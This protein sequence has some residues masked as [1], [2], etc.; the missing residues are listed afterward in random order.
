M[1][2]QEMLTFL[3]NIITGMYN[4]AD[5][6][7]PIFLRATKLLDSFVNISNYPDLLN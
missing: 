7:P 5:P 1:L 3:F 4:I 2:V 6:P